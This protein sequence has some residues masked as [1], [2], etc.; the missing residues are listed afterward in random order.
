M[1]I[2]S[3]IYF[4]KSQILCIPSRNQKSERPTKADTRK[5]HQMDKN[6]LFFYLNTLKESI[7]HYDYQSI[8][9]VIFFNSDSFYCFIRDDTCENGQTVEEILLLVEPY[10][11]LTLTDENLDLFVSSFFLPEAEQTGIQQSFARKAKS[12]FIASIQRSKKN[13]QWDFLLSVCESIRSIREPEP[14][15]LSSPEK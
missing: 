2:F 12:D 13:E 4:D 1:N 14:I 8:S 15:S 5:G 7:Q 11:P 6:Q 9:N 3:S 10:I